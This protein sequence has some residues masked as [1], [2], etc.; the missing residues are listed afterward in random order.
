MSEYNKLVRDKI[1]EII[2]AHG[3][4]PITRILDD[5]EY[6]TELRKKSLE[7]ASE[8]VATQTQEEKIEELAD[9]EQTVLELKELYGAEEVEAVRL[10]K[11]QERGG[12]TARIFLE[13]TE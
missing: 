4:T 13:R 12:F 9:L 7:E 11:L 6:E 3:E 5:Q 10:K 1:P 2:I 8:L